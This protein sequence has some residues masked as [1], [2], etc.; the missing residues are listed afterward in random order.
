MV[1]VAGDILIGRSVEA[2]FDFVADERN[3]P[4][5]NPRLGRAVAVRRSADLRVRGSGR[6]RTDL[7]QRA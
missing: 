4:R 5:Y 3:E 7:L 6:L 2:V 1:R